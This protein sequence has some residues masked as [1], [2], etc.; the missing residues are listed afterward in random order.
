MPTKS[1]EKKVIPITDAKNK[2][3]Y[4]MS[5]VAK[6][7]PVRSVTKNKIVKLKLQSTKNGK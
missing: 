6:Q 7:S 1:N 2:Y 5:V 4:R 3:G